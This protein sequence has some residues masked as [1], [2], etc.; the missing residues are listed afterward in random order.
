[1]T[2]SIHSETGS[3]SRV[4]SFFAHFQALARL[5]QPSSFRE[6][7]AI[8]LHRHCFSAIFVQR[9]KVWDTRYWRKPQSVLVK[10]LSANT[11][12]TPK[13][14]AEQA[15]SAVSVLG[16]T[17]LKLLRVAEVGVGSKKLLNCLTRQLVA[18]VVFGVIRMSLYFMK[19]QHM[20]LFA[21]R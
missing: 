6:A 3:L 10:A 8:E 16:M 17:H 11:G 14:A 19:H 18:A 12:R 20:I 9:K 7:A 5:E 15:C 21:H 2:L 4:P 13:S 1:M